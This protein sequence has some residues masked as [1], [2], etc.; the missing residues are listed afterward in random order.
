MGAL[1]LA[2]F[3][4]DLRP[5][6]GKVWRRP[7]FRARKGPVPYWAKDIKICF[8][9]I[10]AMAEAFVPYCCYWCGAGAGPS[11]DSLIITVSKLKYATAIPRNEM[12]CT[13]RSEI[14]SWDDRMCRV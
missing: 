9:T 7:Q 2:K 8:S 4:P 1:N 10:D 12:G 3:P 14:V 11:A 6:F 13:P 5:F